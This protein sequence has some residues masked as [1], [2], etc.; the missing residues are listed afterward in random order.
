MVDRYNILIVD[1]SSIDRMLLS[2]MVLKGKGCNLSEA[3]DGFSAI[4]AIEA[5]AYDLILLDLIMPDINGLE[6]IRHIRSDAK[7]MDTKILL[8]TSSTDSSQLLATRDPATRADGIIIK[9]YTIAKMLS[10]IEAILT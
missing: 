10:K 6:V 8:I 7:R 1:D 4:K 3:Q 5:K 9:P 2:Q